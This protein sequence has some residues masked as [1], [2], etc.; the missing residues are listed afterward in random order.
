M[1]WVRS[2]NEYTVVITQLV[3]HFNTIIIA[4]LCVRW[5]EGFINLVSR[6]DHCNSQVNFVIK[7]TDVTVSKVP[8]HNTATATTE[9]LNLKETLENVRQNRRT[10]CDFIAENVDE[11]LYIYVHISFKMICK[12]LPIRCIYVVLAMLFKRLHRKEM[13]VK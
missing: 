12:E 5:V 9:L 6:Y 8:E 3:R 10:R 13:T 2:L 11:T 1:V 7:A 4:M